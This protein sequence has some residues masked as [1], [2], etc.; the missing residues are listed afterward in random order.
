MLYLS[1]IIYIFPRE[2]I[3]YLCVFYFSVFVFTE[4][5]SLYLVVLCTMTIKGFSSVVLSLCFL[6]VGHSS[7][8][9]GD[10]RVSC[11]WSQQETGERARSVF[12]QIYKLGYNIGAITS[13]KIGNRENS[14]NI[15]MWRP[16]LWHFTPFSDNT[17]TYMRLTWYKHK[18][19]SLK[20]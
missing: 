18:T 8:L 6:S 10:L 17:F 4:K 19:Y 11:L 9:D 15:N 2:I 12:A 1:F 16:F 7:T 5:F 3:F 14:Y 13:E 20:R